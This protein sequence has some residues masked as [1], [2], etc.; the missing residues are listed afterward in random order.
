VAL[1]TYTARPV[2]ANVPFTFTVPG[3]RTWRILAVTATL[4]RATGGLPTRALQLAVTNGTQ[5]ILASPAADAGTEPGTLTVT[6]T[7]AQPSA[8][9]SGG[10]GLTL[11]PFPPIVVYPGYVLTGTVL[12]AATGDQWTAAYAWVDENPTN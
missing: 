6:W 9:S 7:N 3:Q 1:Q 10:T 8:I 11:G 12:N 2:A 4:S 5:T